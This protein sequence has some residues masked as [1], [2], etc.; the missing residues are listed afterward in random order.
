MS[1]SS[2]SGS[3]GDVQAESFQISY[4]VGGASIKFAETKVDNRNYVSG[5]NREGRTVALT[6][7]F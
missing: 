5:T 4:S 3:T 2:N 7:A 6:L 1:Q